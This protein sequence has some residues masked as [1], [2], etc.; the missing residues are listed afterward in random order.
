M[1]HIL[2]LSASDDTDILSKTLEKNI[3]YDIL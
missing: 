1:E 3:G 2:A